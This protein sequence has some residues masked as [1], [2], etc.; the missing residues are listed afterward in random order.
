MDKNMCVDVFGKDISILRRK[1]LWLFDMDGTIY[2]EERL[3]DGT[4]DLLNYIHS[5]GGRYVFI[6]NNSSKSIDDYLTKVKR[7]GIDASEDNFFTSAQ[8]AELYLKKHHPGELIYCQGT[9][10][11]VSGLR[12]AGLYVTEDVDKEA[13]V[14]LV[15]FDTE[16]T[17]E[18]VRRTCEM[19][20]RN[21]TYLATNPDLCCPVSFGFIPDCGAICHMLED[22]TGKKPVYLGKPE[23]S[24]VNRVAE[25]YGYRIEDICVV[26]DRLYTDV[27]TGLNAGVTAVAVL[28]G[29]TSVEEIIKSERKPDFTFDDVKKIYELLN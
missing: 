17:S 16:L 20:Q 2:E 26:G 5:I 15:G 6:T 27:A 7:L 1:H 18:K 8:S 9:H 3:F 22:A 13:T 24:M 4:I 21:V 28:T 11:F 25:K 10:S 14:V 23:A 19:L 12:E 29:E